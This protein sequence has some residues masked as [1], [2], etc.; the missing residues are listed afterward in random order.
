MKSKR[1]K[2]AEAIV[3]AAKSFVVKNH[4]RRM[5]EQEYLNLF[6]RK[7]DRSISAHTELTDHIGVSQP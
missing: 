4:I 6:R 7:C 2:R 5:S 3:R 1:Q